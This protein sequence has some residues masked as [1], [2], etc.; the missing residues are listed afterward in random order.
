MSLAIDMSGEQHEAN[1]A[2]YFSGFQKKTP[3]VGDSIEIKHEVKRD[4]SGQFVLGMQRAARS[5]H[6]SITRT[7]LDGTVGTSCGAVWEVKLSG[8]RCKWE[9]V[10]HFVRKDEEV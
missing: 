2:E 3:A 5:E 1:A 7:Y 4:T 10:N 8:G 9:T 6:T